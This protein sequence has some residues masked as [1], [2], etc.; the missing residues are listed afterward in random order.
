MAMVKLIFGLPML[1]SSDYFNMINDDGTA[2]ISYGN[3][4]CFMPKIITVLC[5]G[6]VFDLLGRRFA[7]TSIL[8]IYGLSLAWL[9][10]TS[11]DRGVFLL[12]WV[13]NTTA[14]NLVEAS[15]LIVDYPSKNAQGKAF[16]F[17]I[18]GINSGVLFGNG[19]LVTFFRNTDFSILFTMGG[20]CILAFAMVTPLMVIEPPDLKKKKEKIMA[21]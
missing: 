3:A 12:A 5:V 7:L 10:Y 16:A 9:P 6:L 14:L 8:I 11:P 19:I 18:L 4:L 20:I 13:I 15:P 1:K 2:F 17:F 21:T